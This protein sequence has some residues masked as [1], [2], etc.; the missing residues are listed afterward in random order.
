MLRIVI[1]SPYAARGTT[2]VADN[3]QFLAALIRGQL[4]EGQAPFA[5]HAFYT[6]FLDDLVPDERARG[7]QAGLRWTEAADEVWFCLRPGEVLSTGMCLAFER[8]L[9]DGLAHRIRMVRAT[10]DGQI[11]SRTGI[12]V[13]PSELAGWYPANREMP[14]EAR[15]A[16]EQ[17]I[18]RR[19]PTARTR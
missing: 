11:L 18:A 9:R 15:G 12:V 17:L 16:W 5:M 8:D 10:P 6:Q 7:I 4:A 13:T 2:T 14:A 1:E 3:E 19:S